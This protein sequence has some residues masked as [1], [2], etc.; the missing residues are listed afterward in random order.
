V[1]GEDH[2]AVR[3]H[4]DCVDLRL[5]VYTRL[6]GLAVTAPLN[7]ALE[8][9]NYHVA[10][11]RSDAPLKAQIERDVAAL[12][13]LHDADNKWLSVAADVVRDRPNV[14]V[15]LLASIDG[16]E[17]FLAAI[18]AGVAGF[19]SA[20]SSVQAIVR[21]VDSVRDSG[22]AIPRKFVAPLVEHVRHGRGHQVMASDGPIDVTDRE[23]QV[24][25][26]LVQRRSTKEIAGELFVSVGTV[27]S[28]VSSLLHKLGAIDRDNV[29]AMIEGQRPA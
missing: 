19:C 12:A 26:L 3:P 5:R 29:I 8:Q 21:T 24:L 16:P 25:Q 22:V 15:V 6:N 10:P 20:T 11:L 14:D 9:A 13:I 23:W 2:T 1:T 18:S 4:G 17:Q 27:R 7:A 28:H